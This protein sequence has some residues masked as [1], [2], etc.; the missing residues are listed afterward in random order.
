[1]HACTHSWNPASGW[2]TTPGPD[3]ASAQLVL[4]FGPVDA[5]APAWFSAI[6]A[7]CPQAQHVYVSGG[8]QIHGETLSD[9]QTVV[10]F[11]TFAHTAVHPIA[12]EGVTKESSAALGDALGHQLA[13]IADLRHVLVFAEGLSFNAAAFLETLNP[14]LPTGVRI[15]GGLASN[16]IA[17][18]QSVV[19][20]NGPPKPGRLVAIGLS[21]AA[22]HVGTGS[23]GGWDHF[24]PERVVTRA[25][26]AAVHEL[27]GER[28]LDVYRRYLGALAAE[29]PGSALLFPLA[30]RRGPDT[31]VAVRTILGIDEESGTLF[32][33]GDIPEGSLVR[34]MR[35][36]TDKL[37][38]GA[39]EA[40]A[41]ARPHGADP[42]S[43]FTLCV[44]CI[45]RRAVMRSRVEEELEEVAHISGSSTVV[46]FYSNGEIAPPLDGR[47]H[48]RA[49]LHNQTMT[50][51]TFGEH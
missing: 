6:A 49:V 9:E 22:L 23:V 26:V 18:T 37:V 1:M 20:L 33:A 50:V 10:S 44:S 45:G 30:V 46:G 24:G 21:G 2:S 29:L 42:R 16:G 14:L 47:D 17:L 31:A 8:G 25:S 41:L 12:L 43:T 3:C 15:S 48:A 51:T 5:P 19:G 13:A 40:A 27:D 28:A 11:L 32:F 38:D 7:H 4:S 35:T 39:G 34:L 36:T